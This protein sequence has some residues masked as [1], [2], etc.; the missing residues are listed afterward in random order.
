[1]FV[2]QSPA[3]PA[4]GSPA[5]SLQTRAGVEAQQV[6]ERLQ[7]RQNHGM[8]QGA[9]PS[10]PVALSCGAEGFSGLLITRGSS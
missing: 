6:P 3:R 9:G 5:W 1:M 8:Q 2:L 4:L 7:P 10:P